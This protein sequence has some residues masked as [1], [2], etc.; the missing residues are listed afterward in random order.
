MTKASTPEYKSVRKVPFWFWIAVA[1]EGLLTLYFL[2][3]Q[4]SEAGSAFLFGFSASRLALAFVILLA[5]FLFLGFSL[6]S[7]RKNKL[8]GSLSKGLK[9]Q[10]DH[11]AK[12]FISFAVSF[13]LFS[14]I[15]AFLALAL[16]Q[17]AQ[18]LVIL[19]SLL[20]RLAPALIWFQL[21]L[22]QIW[23]V[24]FI[25][26]RESKTFRQYFPP[27]MLAVLFALAILVYVG[28]IRIFTS[29][30]WDLRMRDLNEYIFWLPAMLLVWAAC[31]HFFHEK[32]WFPRINRF[33]LLLSIF[34]VTF[35]VYRHSGQWMGWANTPSKAT[36]HYLADAF[37]H[38]H[39]YLINPESTHDLT[40]FNGNWYVP[41]PPL[42]AFIFL[43]LVALR[44]VEAINTTVVSIFIGALNVVFLYLILEEAN[45]R[46]L[47][48]ISQKGIVWLL[49]IFAF[50][51]C[52]WWLSMMGRVWFISQILTFF[53]SALAILFV[54]K[55]YS[56]WL[57]GISLGLAVLARPNIFTLWPFL[58]GIFIYFMQQETSRL[59]YGKILRWSV[60][61]AV[62]V[63]AAAGSLLFYNYLRFGNFFDFGYVTINSSA[64]IMDAVQTYGM[65][66]IHFLPINLKM[67]FLQFPRLVLDN[68]CLR[69][70]ASRD[71][72]SIFAMTPVFIYAFRRFQ[73]NAWFIGAWVSVILSAALLLL[74]HNT[75]AWQLGYRYVMDFIMPLL[76]IVAVGMGKQPSWLFKILALISIVGSVA[77]IV[78]WFNM[79]PCG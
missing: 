64:S 4:P 30:T 15:L 29:A 12:F 39:L 79:W 59:E 21:V 26:R 16:S 33:F 55:R 11:P 60:Q 24:Y 74:Y 6:A 56:P 54:L 48:A 67:M 5:V 68:A 20:S 50:G 46:K 69:F 42:A 22:V 2:L 40:F 76:T 44:G 10:L 63:V 37:L 53:F 65:F 57:A 41:E 18:E 70:S 47:F 34:L 32:A 9:R 36:W 58:L 45:K 73:K 14:A 27:L 62:P 51:T 25:S 78:W 71:G 13:A 19:R 28:A 52:H 66:N 8:W 43:P 35:T 3:N 7:W 75:G 38:G 61:S 31:H 1:A 49:A 17:A 72:Y 77:G 23:L